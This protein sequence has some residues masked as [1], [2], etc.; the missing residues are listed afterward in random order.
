[1]TDLVTR[2]VREAW[3]GNWAGLWQEA[4]RAVKTSSTPVRKR[5]FQLQEDARAINASIKDNLLC[6]A[7]S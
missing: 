5:D 2:R 4:D 1:L 3:R 7:N 6:K